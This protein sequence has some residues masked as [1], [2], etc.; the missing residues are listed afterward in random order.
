MWRFAY[1]KRFL[2]GIVVGCVAAALSFDVGTPE[3]ALFH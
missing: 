1:R 3:Q 2:A